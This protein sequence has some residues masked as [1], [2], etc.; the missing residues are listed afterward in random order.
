MSECQGGPYCATHRKDSWSRVLT[1]VGTPLTVLHMTSNEIHTGSTVRL[2]PAFSRPAERDLRLVV[3]EING[4]AITARF[5][6]NNKV[7]SLAAQAFVL[8]N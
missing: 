5:T 7:V 2:D 6:H 8:V 4:G 3:T 1:R